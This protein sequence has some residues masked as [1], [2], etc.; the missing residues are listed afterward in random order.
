MT[1]PADLPPTTTDIFDVT[2]ESS[3]VSGGTGGTSVGAFSE[4]T[5]GGPTSGSISAGIA[6]PTAQASITPPTIDIPTT[7]GSRLD[8][9]LDLESG[10]PPEQGPEGIGF[11]EVFSSGIVTGAEAAEEIFGDAGFGEFDE[12][13]FDFDM[14]PGR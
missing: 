11:D 6:T 7:G 9:E 3:S 12:E 2:G 8:A 4:P 5:L 1:E 10:P 14:E 13:M